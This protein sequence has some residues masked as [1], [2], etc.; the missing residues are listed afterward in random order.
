MN[1]K[2]DFKKMIKQPIKH[3]K[4]NNLTLKTNIMESVEKKILGEKGSELYFGERINSMKMKYLERTRKLKELEENITL[5]PNITS[6][7]F[8]IYILVFKYW[9][10][11]IYIY[12]KDYK[13]RD[14]PQNYQE[15]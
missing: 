15:N 10:I 13:D 2:E 9:H 6:D 8:L 4:Y 11:Y 12:R 5:D 3:T 7:L 1:E 14:S